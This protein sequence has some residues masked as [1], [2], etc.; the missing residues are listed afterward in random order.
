[1]DEEDSGQ[2]NDDA[3]A[4]AW[5]MTFADLMS[6]L[7]CFFVLLLSFSE[8]DVAKYKQIAGSMR[9]AFGVQREVR[10]KEPPKGINI[11]AQE[12]SAG[13]PDP[14]PFNIVRQMTT[15]DMKRYLDM[16][17]HRRRHHD[18]KQGRK[19]GGKRQESA[20][21]L[22][23][24]GD[25]KQPGQ[26]ENS[27]DQLVVMPKAEVLALMQARKAARQRRVLEQR[28]K[29]IRAALADQVRKGDIEVLREG[30]K[31]VIRI[32]E[33][34]TFAPG[35]DHLKD[36]FRPTLMRIGRLLKKLPGKVTV[37]GHTD[38]RPIFNDHFRSNWDL[39]AARAVSVLLELIEEAGLSPKRASVR[40]LAD[41]RP[42]VPN[43]TPAHRA[44]NRRV[45]IV[46]EQG[47]DLHVRTPV[48]ARSRDAAATARRALAKTREAE[49]ARAEK[50]RKAAQARA[51]RARA[52]HPS[53][54]GVP[55]APAPA[56]RGKAAGTPGVKAPG[57]QGR[58]GAAAP[59]AV[60]AP[61]RPAAPAPARPQADDPFVAAPLPDDL[62]PAPR[63]GAS[64]H[65]G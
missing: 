37:V 9:E 17:R 59:R 58:G 49:V 33:R 13:R 54:P 47:D 40:G 3:G 55:A 44:R 22:K 15:D 61:G 57:P 23:A 53:G 6:L 21:D 64:E 31:I 16:G 65:G 39:S 36:S 24:G 46:I 27:A 51:D 50:A 43:D 35:S 10:V 4:P 7:M 63:Q 34:A 38:D 48:A 28:V 25:H 45:E 8:M 19:G 26:I 42:L 20:H 30:M 29:A 56:S 18:G 12:F 14:T 52:P 2:K 60:A 41:T 32:R 1:M 62:L 5:V 11:I